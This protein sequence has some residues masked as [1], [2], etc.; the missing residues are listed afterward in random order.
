MGGT[1]P[2]HM[3]LDSIRSRAQQARGSNHKQLSFTVSAL[4]PASTSLMMN[5]QQ[6]KM[7]A[8]INPFSTPADWSQCLLHKK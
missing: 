2:G 8:N 1:I 7:S 5:H 6:N 3:G 4:V